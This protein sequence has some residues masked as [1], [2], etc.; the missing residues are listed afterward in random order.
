MINPKIS[1]FVIILFIIIQTGT[2]PLF[3]IPDKIPRVFLSCRFCQI[4]FGGNIDG[5]DGIDIKL[6]FE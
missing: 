1:Q 6:G 4:L 2:Q 3:F 5:I